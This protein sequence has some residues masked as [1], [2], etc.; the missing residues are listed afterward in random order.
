MD[1][2]AWILLAFIF[3]VDVFVAYIVGR[4]WHVKRRP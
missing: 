2:T 1:T 3:I 4:W